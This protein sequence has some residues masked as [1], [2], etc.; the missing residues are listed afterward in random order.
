MSLAVVQLDPNLGLSMLIGSLIPDIDKS[1]SM[2]GRHLFIHHFLT[3]RKQTHSLVVLTVVFGASLFFLFNHWVIVLG[4]YIGCLS[5][6]LLDLYNLEGVWLFW[7]IRPKLKISFRKKNYG[8]SKPVRILMYH[9]YGKRKEKL[10]DF[11][12]MS[13]FTGMTVLLY[14]LRIHFF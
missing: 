12:L 5:H 6:V 1:N 9:L 13:V 11:G 3:H 14:L 4:F 2:I 8:R 10:I 7:P